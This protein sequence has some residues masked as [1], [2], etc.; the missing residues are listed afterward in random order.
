MRYSV[1]ERLSGMFFQTSKTRPLYNIW[2]FPI[3]HN[4]LGQRQK[5]WFHHGRFDWYSHFY[6][7]Q[8]RRFVELFEHHSGF[9]H[10]SVE[11]CDGQILDSLQWR[12]CAGIY[13][14]LR[15]RFV[16]DLWRKM[17]L[18]QNEMLC[19]KFLWNLGL[20]SNHQVCLNE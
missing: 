1:H 20:L 13:Q 3:F 19:Q 7:T 12:Q 6:Q 4:I 9:S 16:Q 14:S 10:E 2:I 17:F 5:I 8:G 18:Y 15:K 11:T